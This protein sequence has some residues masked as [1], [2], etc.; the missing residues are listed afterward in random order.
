MKRSPLKRYALLKQKTPLKRKTKLKPQS[1]KATAKNFVWVAVKKERARL[2][3]EKFGAVICEKCGKPVS[4]PDGHHNKWRSHG[5]KFT[6][7][8][9]RLVCRTCHAFMHDNNIYDLPGLL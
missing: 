5:G 4:E 1:E 6:L 2:L 8:N 7:E 3:T 9:A